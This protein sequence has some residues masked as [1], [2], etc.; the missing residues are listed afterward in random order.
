MVRLHAHSF[1]QGEWFMV[2]MCCLLDESN[3]QN[4]LDKN[5]QDV[6]GIMDRMC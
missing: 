5:G 4:V 3:G 2:R 1:E 6:L